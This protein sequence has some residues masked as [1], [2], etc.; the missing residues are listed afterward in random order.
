MREIDLIPT[1]Y[2]RQQRVREML[3][4][5]GILYVI[6]IAAVI[7]G[8]FY[9]DHRVDDV[10]TRIRSLEEDQKK[11]AEQQRVIDKLKKDRD[12]VEKQLQ[13]VKLL[14]EGGGADQIFLV[15]DRVLDRSVWMDEWQYETADPVSDKDEKDRRRISIIG[16]AVD[17]AA[18]S[19][20]VDR[21][22]D[23]PEIEDVAVKKTAMIDRT[24]NAVS[25]EMELR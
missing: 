23:Q 8:K 15:F 16:K 6:L 11:L 7:A 17:H 13:F 24:S 20:F 18:L 4:G 10:N 3:I 22:L 21:L 14:Q 5:F 9:L 2:R 25:F 1:D 12:A 19:R